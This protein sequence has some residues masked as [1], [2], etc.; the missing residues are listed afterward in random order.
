MMRDGMEMINYIDEF[1]QRYDILMV[2]YFSIPIFYCKVKKGITPEQL[3]KKYTK[4]VHD[5]NDVLRPHVVSGKIDKCLLLPNKLG[6]S[7]KKEV[8]GVNVHMFQHILPHDGWNVEDVRF[9]RNTV[10][11]WIDENTELLGQTFL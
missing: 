3:T 10:H 1:N 7:I 5:I 8:Y 4:V 9:V 11:K 2:S 6:F